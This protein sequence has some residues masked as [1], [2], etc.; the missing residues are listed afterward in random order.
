M[1]I[2]GII[3]LTLITMSLIYGFKDHLG[4]DLV[5]EINVFSSPYHH[6]GV[7]FFGEDT[8]THLVETLVIGLVFINIVFVFYKKKEEN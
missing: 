7:S 4:I 6:L 3:L 2:L 5:F 1:L 8:D